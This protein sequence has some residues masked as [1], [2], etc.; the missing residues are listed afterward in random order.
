MLEFFDKYSESSYS[1]KD[2]RCWPIILKTSKNMILQ[3][4][5]SVLPEYGF[6]EINANLDFDECFAISEE[7][8]ITFS[9]L[10]NGSDIQINSAVYSRKIGKSFKKL[11]NVSDLIKNIFEGFIVEK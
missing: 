5:V 2:R 3:T 7:C 8:E 6:M 1:H 11:K 9:L 4:L 10:N